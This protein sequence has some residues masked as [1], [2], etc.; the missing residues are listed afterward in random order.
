MEIEKKYLIDT[1]P[2]DVPGTYKKRVIEQG[3]LNTSPVVRVRR[4]NDSYY[5]T[6]K[7]SGLMAREE[8]NLPLDAKAYAHLIKKSDGIII[9]K[10]RYEIP[11]ENNLVIELDIFHGEYE[12]LII[13]EVEFPSIEEADSFTPPEWFSRDVTFDSTYH[14]SNMSKENTIFHNRNN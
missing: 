6:Y 1:L 3:Y 13:A 4:D 11:I 9:T 2:A 7:S 8:Y 12:G 10:D 14:N 5:L